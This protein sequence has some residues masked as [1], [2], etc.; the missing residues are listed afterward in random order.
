MPVSSPT[1]GGSAPLDAAPVDA[2]VIGGGHNGL[3]S[4]ALLA[5]HGWDVVVLEAQ[6]TAGGAVRSAELVPG[7]R[8]DLF[9]AFY[10]MAGASPALRG[11]GLE[12]H[13]LRW[14][15]API[16]YGH[17]RGPEDTDAAV[18]H[19]DAEITAEALARRDSRDGR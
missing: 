13:G 14:S 9:S 18:V 6:D 10:P 16:V 1:P 5:D 8:M 2:V 17:P 3:V 19:P 4:A 12:D 7:Y 15:R 11:L